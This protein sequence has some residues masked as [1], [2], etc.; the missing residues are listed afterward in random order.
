LN[1]IR[2]FKQSTDKLPK[3]NIEKRAV[4]EVCTPSEIPNDEILLS[5]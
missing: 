4:L 1:I 5:K 3:K 2:L